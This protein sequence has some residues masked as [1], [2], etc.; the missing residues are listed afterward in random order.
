MAK[1][2]RLTLLVLLLAVSFG[3]QFS[4]KKEDK[5]SDQAAGKAAARTETAGVAEE[6]AAHMPQEKKPGEHRPEGSVEQPAQTPPEK[7]ADQKT[8]YTCPMHPEYVSDK[9]GNCP[10]CGMTLVPV[11]EEKHEEKA[12]MPAGTVRI[13]PEIQQKIGV[14]F[15]TVEF[16]PLEKKIRASAHIAYDESRIKDVNTKFHGWV[17][18]LNADFTGRL[19]KKGEPLFSIY[20]PELVSA[21]EEYLLALKAR[22]LAAKQASLAASSE[23]LVDSSRK[24]LAYWDL[25]EEQL[26]ELER[27]RHALRAVTFYA[28]F[29][30]FVIQK[31]IVQGKFV[32]AGETLYRI[33]D[34]S[35]VWLMAD[36]Y[37][38]D[39]PSV[40]VGQEVSIE[41]P[42]FPGEKL[43]GRISYL[44]P[45]L[46]N[47]TRTVKARV[48][49]SNRGFRLK[50][51]MFGSAEI[52]IRL[53][54]KLSL[55]ES[56]VLDSGTRK[57][58]FV[59]RGDGYLEARDVHLG[60]TAD[61]YFEALH[62][63]KDGE[64]VVT[65]ANFLVDSESKLKS[66]L[67]K[68]HQH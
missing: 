18:S 32:M 61:G 34:I 39:V 9:P 16:R 17:E 40:S 5:S 59:D 43:T 50:P 13:S 67:Q 65:S 28:P 8:T 11:K 14:T 46:E 27:S 33:A 26:K 57:I 38:Q 20:S 56:A 60:A 4:C 51:E 62:G 30:G 44:Y 29:T 49:L 31:E 1:A 10:I 22:D 24:R 45:Y 53:G 7:S 2:I 15:G 36:L 12:G 35:V 25:T 48:E 55:P 58:V 68:T 37:E 6:H 66:A 21:Q 41:L 3:Y 42:F 52:R 63:V 54:R 47:M 19:V 23:T 64:R